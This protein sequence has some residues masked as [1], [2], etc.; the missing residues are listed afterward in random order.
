M[1]CSCTAIPRF[2]R[3]SCWRAPWTFTAR[4]CGAR[5][6]SSRSRG[7]PCSWLARS[8][9]V[10]AS[11]CSI[12][13]RRRRQDHSPG[14][15]DGGRRRARGCRAQPGTGSRA[16]RAPSS[17]SAR[18]TSESSSPTRRSRAR[19]VPPSTASWSIPPCLGLGTLQARPD[20]R[21]RVTCDSVR[22]MAQRQAA[23]L[24]AGAAPFVR[25]AC[26]STLLARSPQT[27]TS[28]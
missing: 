25:A 10:P 23:I 14:R 24:A 7:G 6:S 12:C 4:R 13:V 20:L 18:G 11:G 5:A 9:R 15:A 1:G 8:A 19:A 3:R 26:L 28:T 17:A 22:E 27:R 2:Q 16:G 21:W